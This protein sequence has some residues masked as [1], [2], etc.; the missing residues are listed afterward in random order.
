MQPVQLSLTPEEGLTPS[1]A[2]AGSLPVLLLDTATE[3]LGRLIA[4]AV[5]ST[6]RGDGNE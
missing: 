5:A 6:N 3:M 2:V 4:Q 1:P